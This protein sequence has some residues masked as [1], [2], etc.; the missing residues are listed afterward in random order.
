M[1]FGSIR[2]VLSHPRQ[3]RVYV[4]PHDGMPWSAKLEDAPR[5]VVSAVLAAAGFQRTTQDRSDHVR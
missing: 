4:T 3:I 1:L 2:V 5:K